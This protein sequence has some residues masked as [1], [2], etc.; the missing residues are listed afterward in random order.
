MAQKARSLHISCLMLVVK[1]H[2][3]EHQNVTS[4][5]GS[6]RSW[7]RRKPLIKMYYIK[8]AIKMSIDF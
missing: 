1:V 5:R 4:W 8:K 6:K 3:A 7:E 2:R